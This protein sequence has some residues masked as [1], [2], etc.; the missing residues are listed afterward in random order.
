MEIDMCNRARERS[1]RAFLG[2]RGPYTAVK[3]VSWCTGWERGGRE[4]RTGRRV[5]R[6]PERKEFFVKAGTPFVRGELWWASKRERKRKVRKAWKERRKIELP[7]A[8][9]ADN[10]KAFCGR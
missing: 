6:L 4:E 3:L 9:K 10:G 8:R 5:G 7:G 2:C 1:W